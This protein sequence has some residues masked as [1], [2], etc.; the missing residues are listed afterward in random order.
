[1]ALLLFVVR[2]RDDVR[3][4]GAIRMLR[5]ALYG[6]DGPCSARLPFS[7]FRFFCFASCRSFIRLLIRRS[8]ECSF[9][10]FPVRSFVLRTTQRAPKSGARAMRAFVSIRGHELLVRERCSLLVVVTITSDLSTW[11]YFLSDVRRA[12]HVACAG[13]SPRQCSVRLCSVLTQSTTIVVEINA[14]DRIDRNIGELFAIA[15][16]SPRPATDGSHCHRCVGVFSLR[17]V[18]SKFGD[19]C[20]HILVGCTRAAS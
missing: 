19:R 15:G 16:V 6:V 12:R 10:R 11:T 2:A 1:M 7:V 20:S 13:R 3:R 18:S 17:S 14:I 8:F 5:A 9:V 4:I